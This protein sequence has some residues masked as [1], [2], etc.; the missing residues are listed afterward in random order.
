[1]KR[2]IEK[3]NAFWFPTTSTLP[4]AIC[5]IVA[6]ACQL[7]WF[8]PPLQEQLNLLERNR[9]FIDPQLLIQA[10]TAV[11]PREVIFTP[12]AF[13]VF[14]RAIVVVGVVA[15]LGFFTRTS[16]FLFALGNWILVAH[17]YSYSDLHHPEAVFSIF[18][19]A[20]A[21]AP[22]GDRL[23][24]DALIRR[25]RGRATEV[26]ARV[27]TAMWPLK[28]GQ[29]LLAMAYFST[30]ASKVLSG[31]LSWMNGYLEPAQATGS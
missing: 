27:D 20:L 28:L 9:D 24:I 26:P 16:L 22:S 30:G 2:W 23:S 6:V 14:Y 8:M 7:L 4:L 12:S 19:M 5:R 21:F 18:L 1:V 13:P 17:R 29:V 3:W 11:I 25:L 10:L 31:G 15:L